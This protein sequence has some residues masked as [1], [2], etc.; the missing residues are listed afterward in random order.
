M[1]SR[2]FVIR[3]GETEWSLT[4]RHTSRTDLALTEKGERDAVELGAQLR[5][6]DFSL[7]LS[8]PSLRARRTCELAGLPK[9]PEID[10]DLVEWQYG[11]YEGRRTAEIVRERPG[12]DLFRDGAPGGESPDQVAVRVDRALGRLRNR[13]G[14][15]AVFCHGHLAHVLAARWIELPVLQSRHFSVAPASVGVLALARGESGPPVIALWNSRPW[16]PLE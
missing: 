15:V 2:I 6:V 14:D 13:P 9:P 10:P 5:R 4:G 8:S 12:W 1:A 11:E 7:V 16:R 3:H